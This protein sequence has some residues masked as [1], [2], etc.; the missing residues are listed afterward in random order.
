M[1]WIIPRHNIKN[2]FN[3]HFSLIGGPFEIGIG[4]V[5]KLTFEDGKFYLGSTKN[6]KTRF[7]IYRNQ[8]RKDVYQD[9]KRV[10]EAIKNNSFA[11]FEIIKPIKTIKWLK[12]A[13]D[14]VL[15]KYIGDPLLINR[16]TNAFSNKG[17]KWT[18]EEIDKSFKNNPMIGKRGLGKKNP[19]RNKNNN[20]GSK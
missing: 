14:R 2:T 11:V 5:Y 17:I 3:S 10:N 9:S 19:L 8:F 18:K 4:G 15:K 7:L 6:F 20:Y 1:N 13:E 12:Y 16:S